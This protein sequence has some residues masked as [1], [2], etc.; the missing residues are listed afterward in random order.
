M[1]DVIEYDR[2]E[3]VYKLTNPSTGEIVSE[4][5]AG[6]DGRQAAHRESVKL[7]SPSLYAL[8]QRMSE[9]NPALTSRIWKAT[10]ILLSGGVT[11][12]D[13]ETYCVLSQSGNEYG[14]YIVMVLDDGSLHCDC[15]DYAPF[16]ES[17]RQYCKHRLAVVMATQWQPEDDIAY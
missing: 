14:D 15:E 3:R 5:P 13:G 16:L 17:G 8:A 11:S 12:F 6:R 4:F 2:S 7:L 9:R 1:L 10:E